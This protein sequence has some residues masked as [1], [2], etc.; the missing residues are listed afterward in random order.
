MRNTDWT[1]MPEENWSLRKDYGMLRA[2]EARATTRAMDALF[3][4]GAAPWEVW[5]I[6]GS[7]TIPPDADEDWALG[8]LSWLERNVKSGNQGVD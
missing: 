5:M 1:T 4:S 6:L 2:S 3:H 8:E 7:R